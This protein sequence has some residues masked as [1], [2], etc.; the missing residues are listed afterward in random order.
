MWK[1]MVFLGLLF[2][3]LPIYHVLSDCP[4]GT[5][6][7]YHINVCERCLPE[8][9]SGQIMIAK[10]NQTNKFICQCPS[11]KY[12]DGNLALCQLCK[13]C[14]TTEIVSQNCTHVHNRKCSNCPLGTFV[15]SPYQCEKCSHCEEGEVVARKCNGSKDTLCSRPFSRKPLF[16]GDSNKPAFTL[17]QPEPS[18]DP[19]KVEKNNTTVVILSIMVALFVVALLLVCLC[20]HCSSNIQRRNKYP[21]SSFTD[22][23]EIDDFVKKRP[24]P[25]VRETGLM[26]RDLNPETFEN[27]C[28]L[29]NPEGSRNWKVLAGKLG[30]SQCKIQNFKLNRNEACQSLLQE[31]GTEGNTTVYV[32]YNHLLA[33]Q[34][35]DC[36][37]LLQKYLVQENQV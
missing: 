32:L 9:R 5:Y 29:L 37:E 2:I 33:M 28:C 20:W 18:D 16:I 14:G 35:D 36:T 27:L 24:L 8:C 4:I 1:R 15:K 12:W 3:L 13:S 7:S 11:N 25:P 31:W 21:E 19:E 22:D 10:C 17:T 26:L 23:S 6:P 34:R 30:Y